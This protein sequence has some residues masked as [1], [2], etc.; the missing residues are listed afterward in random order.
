MGSSQ[1]YFHSAQ[2]LSIGR[3]N[4][5]VKKKKKAI[6]TLLTNVFVYSPH[7]I[8]LS[9]Q[10][11]LCIS[12]G[13]YVAMLECYLHKVLLKNDIITN[14]LK[15]FILCMVTSQSPSTKAG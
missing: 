15:L 3:T 7:K 14:T 8:I 2:V 5:K 11:K 1:V 12:Q 13:Y 6:F 4:S 10:F 9:T